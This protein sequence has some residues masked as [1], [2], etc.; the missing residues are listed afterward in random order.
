MPPIRVALLG[1]SQSAKTSWANDAHFPYLQSPHVKEK[2][3]IVALL[4]SSEDAANRAIAAYGLDATTVKGYGD[5][6][7]LA[8]D[9]NVDLVVCCTRVDLHYD[10][11]RPSVAAG[12]NVYVEWP[13]ASD[14]QDARELASLARNSGAQTIVGLQARVDPAI[15]K[16]RQLLE[17]EVIGKVL[18]SD[19]SAYSP[20]SDRHEISDGLG[21]F[22]EKRV[23]G[24]PVTIMLGH[25]ID[26]VHSVLGEFETFQS[27]T[28]VQRPGQEILNRSDGTRTSKVSDVPDLVSIHGTLATQHPY[29][30]PGASLVVNFHYEPPFPGT[31]PLVWTITGEKGQIRLSAESG[32]LIQTNASGPMTLQVYMFDSGKV[33]DISW[34]WEDWQTALPHRARNI[35]KLYEI[36]AENKT[37]E[38]GVADF[39]AAV[40]RHQEMDAL[41]WK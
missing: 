38:Y 34:G 8:K 7:A 23:G 16:I 1:L 29:V 30:A 6:Q 18:S 37:A 10:T 35:G 2:Y 4:N 14:H 24:N 20:A 27:H 12:K 22:L 19:L 21:Y 31:T 26:A 15:R 25:R 40:K 5:P 17:Q 33:E 41:L 39:D 36:Y 13:L 9:P 28:Q 11:V 3:Q 32:S